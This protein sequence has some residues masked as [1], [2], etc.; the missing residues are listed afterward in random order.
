MQNNCKVTFTSPQVPFY[1]LPMHPPLHV[2]VPLTINK[3]HSRRVELL[4]VVLRA[5]P[6]Q[7]EI[8]VLNKDDPLFS[9][10]NIEMTPIFVFSWYMDGSRFVDKLAHL[11]VPTF[12]PRPLHPLRVRWRIRNNLFTCRDMVTRFIRDGYIMKHSTMGTLCTCH[13]SLTSSIVEDAQLFV[14]VICCTLCKSVI[15]QYMYMAC[16][17]ESEQKLY[18]G[19]GNIL[20]NG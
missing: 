2:L 18:I 6:A 5:L 13:V 14:H 1:L 20:L 9:F 12:S 19:A 3:S 15:I 17:Y 16:K 10:L 4:L 11:A 7:C 8:W